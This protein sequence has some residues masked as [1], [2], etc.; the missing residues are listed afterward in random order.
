MNIFYDD[1]SYEWFLVSSFRVLQVGGDYCLSILLR[2]S[3]DRQA[4]SL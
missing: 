4:S 3:E 2:V 1:S